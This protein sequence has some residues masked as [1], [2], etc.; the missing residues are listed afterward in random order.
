M[1]QRKELNVNGKIYEVFVE[2]WRTL[3]E[4]LREELHLTGAKMGCDD[5]NCGA[6]TV[7]IDGKAIKG[8]L[9][10]VPQ[11]KGKKILTIEGLGSGENLHPLQ[12][13]FI[14]HFAVQCG[15]CTPGMIMSAKAL[16]DE[17]PDATE[18]EI[19]SG[20]QGNICRCTGY[21]KIVEAVE[22]ARDKLAQKSNPL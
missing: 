16:L 20:L 22:A 2:P 11:A 15:F 18:E 1:K 14:D 12:Q 19:R 6:C 4:V 5:G 13:A 9:M 3:L 21:V 8:C 10:L 17:K 7:V